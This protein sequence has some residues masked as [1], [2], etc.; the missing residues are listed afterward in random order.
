M[1]AE[2]NT[3]VTWAKMATAL[4]ASQPFASVLLIVIFGPQNPNTTIVITGMMWCDSKHIC[5]LVLPSLSRITWQP[6]RIEVLVVNELPSK[7]TMKQKQLGDNLG[8]LG[9]E[10]KVLDYKVSVD[11]GDG[12]K[13][14]KHMYRPSV[15]LSSPFKAWHSML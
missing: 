4:F 7:L 3:G 14:W 6:I 8:V 15:S 13:N 2:P 11:L 12:Q 9:L 5:V 1:R 10:D